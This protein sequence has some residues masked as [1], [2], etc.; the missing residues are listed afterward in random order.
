MLKKITLIFLFYLFSFVLINQFN[1]LGSTHP[2]CEN[3]SGHEDTDND[4]TFETA[5]EIKYNH[6]CGIISDNNL[7]KSIPGRDFWKFYLYKEENITIKGRLFTVG[8]HC[9]GTEGLVND[10]YRFNIIIY[11]SSK[12]IVSD[13]HLME[14]EFTFTARVKGWYYLCIEDF[15]YSGTVDYDGNIIITSSENKSGF[16]FD[17][18]SFLEEDLLWLIISVIFIVIAGFIFIRIIKYISRSSR[19]RNKDKCFE[20]KIEL[21]DREIEQ[22]LLEDLSPNIQG[23]SK[24]HD[25]YLPF[26]YQG[27]PV[28]NNYHYSSDD[29]N[30]LLKDEFQDEF[31]FP[32]K[33]DYNFRKKKKLFGWGKKI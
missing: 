28:I 6:Y 9:A 24:D 2:I 25:Q 33:E 31:S 32:F 30:L 23:L 8:Y 17:F 11:D 10:G 16:N 26:N 4:D 29:T 21:I 19:E 12:V 14:W 22:Q 18:L 13:T 5:R 20:K 7:D 1:I 27:L 15:Y 3:P